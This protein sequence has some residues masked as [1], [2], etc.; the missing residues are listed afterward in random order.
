MTKA[1]ILDLVVNNP[2]QSGDVITYTYQVVNSGN[3]TIQNLTINEI[4]ITLQEMVA[5]QYL[6]SNRLQWEVEKVPC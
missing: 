4:W 6:Y 5:Y 3:T 1:S 2:I